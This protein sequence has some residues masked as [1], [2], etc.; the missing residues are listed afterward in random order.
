MAKMAPPPDEPED[1]V[2]NRMTDYVKPG[3]EEFTEAT[4]EEAPSIST[5]ETTPRRSRRRLGDARPP[6][7]RKPK[8]PLPRWRDGQISAF[9]ERLYKAMGGVLLMNPDPEIRI[10]GQGFVDSAI[11]ASI[12]WEKVAKR[13]EIV[14]RFFERIMTSSELGELFWAHLPILVPFFRRFGPMRGSFD[15]LQ[16][17]FD[18][19]FTDAQQGAA[20]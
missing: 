9:C 11:P 8:A 12:A 14:R 2:P 19:E 6:R 7:E 13:H 5:N 1:T 4:P 16:E 18:R 10:I 15:N 17:E 3:E 20:A